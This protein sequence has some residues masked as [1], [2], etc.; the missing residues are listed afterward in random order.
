[1]VGAVAQRGGAGLTALL[2]TGAR[3][4]LG[5]DLVALASD[6]AGAYG[7]S[8]VHGLGSDE[9]DITDGQRVADTLGSFVDSYHGVW[10]ELHED[11]IRLA[12]RD[13]AAE[14]AAGRA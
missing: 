8:A 10:F 6:A 13:R 5:S 14:A 9:L 7:V 3:G 11:L 2:V 12:E 4:Q 1:M